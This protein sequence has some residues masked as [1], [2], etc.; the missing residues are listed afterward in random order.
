M[1]GGDVNSMGGRDPNHNDVET[2]MMDTGNGAAQLMNLNRK[3]RRALKYHLNSGRLKPSNMR[4]RLADGTIIESRFSFQTL[5]FLANHP[6]SPIHSIHSE[7]FPT[8]NSSPSDS[9]IFSVPEWTKVGW[10]LELS[11]Q[12]PSFMTHL[13]TGTKIFLSRTPNRLWTLHFRRIGHGKIE[14]VSADKNLLPGNHDVFF[15]SGMTDDT[16]APTAEI[17]PLPSVAMCDQL[18][19]LS[20]QSVATVEHSSRFSVQC[21][22]DAVVTVQ[23]YAT[24]PSLTHNITDPVPKAITSLP[25]DWCATIDALTDNGP[26]TELFIASIRSAPGSKMCMT[27][28]EMMMRWGHPTVAVQKRLLRD[29]P[30]HFHRSIRA[31]P[32]GCHI[33]L[34]MR[35]SHVTIPSLS[36]HDFYVMAVAV[37]SE[38]SIDFTRRW[39]SCI[40]GFVIA[41][42]MMETRTKFTRAELLRSKTGVWG[43]LKGLKAWCRRHGFLLSHIIGDMDT[44]WATQHGHGANNFTQACTKFMDD[45]DV[46]FSVA[47]P[48]TQH[49]NPVESH[50]RKLMYITHMNLFVAHF[51]VKVWSPSLLHAVQLANQY[52]YPD[53]KLP[54][55]MQST[56]SRALIGRVPD[57]NHNLPFGA[58]CAVHKFSA[59]HNQ[60]EHTTFQGSVI[61]MPTDEMYGFRI[62]HRTYPFKTSRENFLSYDP[63]LS[64]RPLELQQLGLLDTAADNS[65]E[66]DTS[67]KAF[68]KSVHASPVIG[69]HDIQFTIAGNAVRMI[70]RSDKLE[71]YVFV[72]AD[73]PGELTGQSEPTEDVMRDAKNPD[74]D[75]HRQTPPD[76]GFTTVQPKS[77]TKLPGNA[78]IKVQTPNPKRRNTASWKRYERYMTASTVSEY[79]QLGGL[80]EDLRWDLHRGFVTC[81]DDPPDEIIAIL[82][83]DHIISPSEPDDLDVD[84]SAASVTPVVPI[85]YPWDPHVSSAPPIGDISTMVDNYVRNLL[86]VAA[87]NAPGGAVHSAL[88]VEGLCTFVR[89]NIEDE[90]RA[91]E[92]R[93]PDTERDLTEIMDTLVFDHLCTCDP[94]NIGAISTFS[95]NP[96]S[97][98]EVK[99]STRW[100]E[101]KAAMLDELAKLFEQF[102]TFKWVSKSEVDRARAE[103]G[104]TRFLFCKWVFVDKGTRLKARLVSCENKDKYHVDDVWSPTASHDTTRFCL[105]VA[106]NARLKVSSMDVTGAYLWGKRPAGSPRVFLRA[107]TA[108][109]ELGHE[110]FD[111]NGERRYIEVVSNHYGL[112]DAGRVW[113]ACFREWLHEIGFSQSLIDPCLFYIY[114]GSAEGDPL[115]A[116]VEG[117]GEFGLIV[118]Y[119]DDSLVVMTPE[120][121]AWFSAKMAD[122]FDHSPDSD[123]DGLVTKFTG[124]EITQSADFSRIEIRTPD[125]YDRIESTLKQIGFDG[126]LELP[127]VQPLPEDALEKMAEPVS[128]SNP[129]WSSKRFPTRSLLG[130]ASWAVSAARPAEAFSVNAIAHYMHRPTTAVVKCLLQLISWLLVTRSDPIIF[131]ATDEKLVSAM[132]D[133]SLANEPGFKRSFIGYLLKWGPNVFAW[134]VSVPKAVAPSTRD[135][136]YMGAIKGARTLI[137]FS[138]IL[139]E[140]GLHPGEPLPLLTD[141]S[142]T[143]M[144][145]E[146]EYVHSDSRWMGIRLN[147]LRQ[148]QVDRLFKVTWCA[149]DSMLADILTKVLKRIRFL[150]LRPKVMNSDA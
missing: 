82:V 66:L 137:A 131:T 115:T 4:A 150:E 3:N 59:Q 87:H 24:L 67:Y 1:G 63:D 100:P 83:L 136:E 71:G 79:L 99:A 139:R 85:T 130:S 105:I 120:L 43:A 60:L 88:D 74:S 91:A 35:R 15:I 112:R 101:W 145:T 77:G 70:P 129:L 14:L 140:L 146:N 127:A 118:I 122:R 109:D 65:L 11:D 147:W 78:R 142:S 42:V 41:L 31:R 107:P 135:A 73:P 80:P 33:C 141:S 144:S 119:V 149:G 32:C 40:D 52:G 86:N 17:L 121:K 110:L 26:P 20:H 23:E 18:P 124:F 103:N 93:A 76:S 8:K 22:R 72:E 37:G 104:K 27:H 108:I 12:T 49:K 132:T 84:L 81:I 30:H 45:E 114:K 44:M 2:A 64:K 102:G 133:S 46:K 56:P 125:I 54:L 97:V 55:L 98:P 113:H 126:I 39:D 53:S 138:F 68:L 25:T 50:M 95:T 89:T 61:G 21:V 106:C 143:V 34:F 9:H 96:Q 29:F 16:T 94:V 48:H 5:V 38:W 57:P 75:R 58:S 123:V 134:R 51:N 10:K 116:G 128:D 148:G 117:H 36:S 92:G 13:P 62:L 69:T 111:E 90:L 19:P 47:G 28:E 7:A 6:H